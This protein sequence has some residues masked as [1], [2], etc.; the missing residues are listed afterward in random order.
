[1]YTYIKTIDTIA[2]QNVVNTEIATMN[3][4]PVRHAM[5][6]LFFADLQTR[7]KVAGRMNIA[8]WALRQKSK[9]F[10]LMKEA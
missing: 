4:S 1:M 3:Q 5:L 6:F 2:K 10:K 7:M 9:Y 8:R